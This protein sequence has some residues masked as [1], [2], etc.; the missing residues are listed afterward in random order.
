[1]DGTGNQ[2]VYENGAIKSIDYE[3][4]NLKF[5]EPYLLAASA[6]EEG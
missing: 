3:Q 5:T 4:N 2:T 6:N 1:M